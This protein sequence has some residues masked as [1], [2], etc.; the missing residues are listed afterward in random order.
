MY[1]RR[2][3]EKRYRV[4]GLIDEHKAKIA[5]L[6]AGLEETDQADQTDQAEESES[7]TDPLESHKE[8]V[9]ALQNSLTPAEV[10]QLSTLA[11]RL[12]K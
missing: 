9:L 6:E 4:E 12:S 11:N 5:R 2:L 8:S 10:K 7:S 3:S 1:F